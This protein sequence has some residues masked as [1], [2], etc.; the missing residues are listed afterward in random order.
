VDLALRLA[1]HVHLHTSKQ[2]ATARPQFSRNTVD[3]VACCCQPSAPLEAACPTRTAASAPGCHT[4]HG[5]R[6]CSLGLLLLSAGLHSFRPPC[7]SSPPACC[8]CCC[9]CC[10]AS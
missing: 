6:A 3:W 4:G 1:G 5:Q 8:C 2:Q 7:C 9:C 10:W